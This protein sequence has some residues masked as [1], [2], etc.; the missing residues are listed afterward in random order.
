MDDA[1]R[2]VRISCWVGAVVDALAGVQML[3]PPLFAC[4]WG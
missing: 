1:H 4:R 2:W 3:S